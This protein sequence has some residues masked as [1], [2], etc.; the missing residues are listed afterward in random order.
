MGPKCVPVQVVLVLVF[1][2]PSLQGAEEA[3]EAA[4]EGN[5]SKVCTSPSGSSL[6]VQVA[7]TTGCCG[8]KRG[9]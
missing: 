2:S 4:E 6:S 9:S 8:R 1:R 5:G 7:F 3:R